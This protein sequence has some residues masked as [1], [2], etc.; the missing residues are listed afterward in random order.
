VLAVL[1]KE[2]LAVFSLF[3]IFHIFMQKPRPRRERLLIASS[4]LIFTITTVVL[5]RLTVEAYYSHRT[6]FTPITEIRRLLDPH[7]WPI[8]FQAI[9]S[10][11]GVIPVLLL[12]Q[13]R[14]WL[15]FLIKHPEW[16]VYGVLSIA[17][18]FCGI[19]KAR[20]FLY[21]LPMAVV[22]FLCVASA[23]DSYTS[24]RRF[25]IWVIFIL[26]VHWF[27]GGYLSPLGPV[28]EYLD[29]MVPEYS[30][31][32]FVPFLVRNCVL[33]LA[34]FVFTIQFMIREWNFS[35]TRGFIQR[36]TAPDPICSNK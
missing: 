10:G 20:L 30:K 19:D 13:W 35:P 9:F 1:Q 18:L 32:G 5:V 29:K 2:S 27:I 26:L 23:L 17:F 7:F 8:F 12:V 31:G 3:S 36:Q 28:N 16:I 4:V 22:L 15:D 11:L 34:V 25:A 21:F 24:G 33:G 14:P 6:F